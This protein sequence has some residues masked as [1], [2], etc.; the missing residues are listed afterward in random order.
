MP[1]GRPQEADPGN[2]YAFAH[3]FYWDFRRIEEGFTRPRLDRKAYESLCEEIDN[4]ELQLDP[5]QLTKVER[6]ADEGIS[7][8]RLKESE[9][10]EWVQRTKEAWLGTIREDLRRRAADEATKPLKVPGEPEV[11]RRLLDAETPGQV[12]DICNDA[13][14]QVSREISPGIFRELIVPNWP[15]S[16]GSVLPSYLSQY[17]SEFVAA[18]KD[19]RFPRSTNRPTSR[20]KQLWFLSRALA[21]AL[22]GVKTR[23]AINLVGSRRP[24]ESFAES[25]AA[26]PVR[27]RTRPQRKTNKSVRKKTEK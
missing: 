18:R 25:R 17:A 6:M 16:A 9:R 5:R 27:K 11:I 20:L 2:L 4:R 10:S 15:I 8:G 22:Y 21:G 12:R 1:A 26:K 24:E 7:Q 3:Q 14:A 13:F 23:T 19:P